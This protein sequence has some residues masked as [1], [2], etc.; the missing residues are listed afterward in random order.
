MTRTTFQ[1]RPVGAIEF[2]GTD[3]AAA[4]QTIADVKFVDGGRIVDRRTGR[5]LG[6]SRALAVIAAFDDL[7]TFVGT[8]P[9]MPVKRKPRR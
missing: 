6:R 3:T 2:L 9:P 4:I 8:R 1:P 7:A 5:P